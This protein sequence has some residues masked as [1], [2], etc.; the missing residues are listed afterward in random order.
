MRIL[1]KFPTRQRPR[2]FFATLAKYTGMQSHKHDVRFVV[3][4]DNDDKSMND[5]KIRTQLDRIPNLKYYYGNSKSKVQAI[6][7]N[8]DTDFDILLLASDDME[9]VEVGYDDIIVQEMTKHFPDLSGCL[10][11]NDGRRSDKLNTI[12]VMGVNLYKR[13]GY[14]YHP[15]YESLYCDNEYT[16][17]T[18]RM[19]KSAYIDHIIIRHRWIDIT[20][21]EKDALYRRNDLPVMRDKTNYAK[22]K[23]AGFPT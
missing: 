4:M 19:G 12:T 11:F 22:R 5:S 13:F 1:V 7:A 15:S 10:N 6:N 17:V 2:I 8:I 14:I 16:D 3:T 20:G 18:E 9:P 23:A 21:G